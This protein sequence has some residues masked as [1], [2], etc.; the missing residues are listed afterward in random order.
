[1]RSLQGEAGRGSVDVDGD[2][3]GLAFVAQNGSSDGGLSLVRVAKS[4]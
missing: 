2:E 1:M 4:R 3:K